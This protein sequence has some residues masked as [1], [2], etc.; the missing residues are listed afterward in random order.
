[1]IRSHEGI[2]ALFLA[3]GTNAPIE[4]I[5]LLVK[6]KPALVDI[7]NNEEIAPI[8]EAIKHRRLD[9]VKVLINGG[10]NVNAF[11]L[12]LENSLHYAASNC[13]YELID[14]LLNKTEID[15]SAKNR[16]E[17]NPLCLLIV[18]SRNE[19]EDVV[20]SCF[21]LM[22]E[23]TFE[24]DHFSK[25]YSIADIFQPAF[26]A[27]VYSHKEI[28]KYIIHN[29]YSVNNSKFEF[30]KQLFEAF[31]DS[32]N[33]GD[34]D[35]E[36]LFYYLLVFLHDDINRFD[37]FNFPR[38]SEIN[39]FMCVRSVMFVIQKL[40]ISQKSVALALDLITHLEMIGLH[41]ARVREFEDNFGMILY[42]KF[43]KI[44][45]NNQNLQI[46][47]DC[48]RTLL[49]FFMLKKI[50]INNVIRSLLHSIAISPETEGNNL[51]NMSSLLRL[52]FRFNAT[53]FI[54]GDCW[55]QINEFKNLH[56]NIRHIVLW[57]NETFG[58]IEVTCK[59]LDV[60]IVYSL[61]HMCRNLIR[62]KF[63]KKLLAIDQ[64]ELPESLIN[65]VLYVN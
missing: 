12:D 19:T 55:K 43:S 64:L 6:K 17:M 62:Q 39:Y 5:K 1:M 7:K 44:N 51:E 21:H 14:Y 65:Y 53:F 59:I 32:D 46:R 20:S 4:I 63:R 54:D 27:T 38:F 47:I 41:I 35:D 26:L 49:E 56:D 11:D 29:I 2:T 61:K 52:L 18:R 8:H 23:H 36:E 57:I 22:L 45:L 16:D 13:D 3:I 31:E 25:T 28:V 24:K 9:V 40:L 15:S 34:E 30:I 10:A 50:K 60:K 42:N 58:T 33:D 37:R 48:T